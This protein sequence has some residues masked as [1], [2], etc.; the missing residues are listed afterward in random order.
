MERKVEFQIVQQVLHDIMI[1]INS[2]LFLHNNSGKKTLKKVKE[3]KKII[4]I[5]NSLKLKKWLAV[6]TNLSLLTIFL[7][8]LSIF[9]GQDMDW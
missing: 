3:K 7:Q 9:Q 5:G 1:I 2:S 6:K 8:V 4:I